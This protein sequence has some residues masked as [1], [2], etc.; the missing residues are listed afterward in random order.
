MNDTD[1]LTAEDRECR[2]NE[3]GSRDVTV[4]IYGGDVNITHLHYGKTVYLDPE[5]LMSG[6]MPMTLTY[7][8]DED[9]DEAYQVVASAT[10][11]SAE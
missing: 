1:P 2:C 4:R 8:V 11:E 9:N 5:Y 3:F 6:D 10:G 7:S